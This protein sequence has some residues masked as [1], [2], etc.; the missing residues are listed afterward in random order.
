MQRE[1]LT[2]DGLKLHTSEPLSDAPVT[3]VAVTE[4]LLGSALAVQ[5]KG[6]RV[7][8]DFL[9][10]VSR[11]VGGDDTLARF[12]GLEKKRGKVSK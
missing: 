3:A 10:P 1:R 9:I 7:R 12:D 5:I 11:L 2:E 6:V 8:E 4:G